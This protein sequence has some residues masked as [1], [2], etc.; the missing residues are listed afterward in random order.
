MNNSLNNNPFDFRKNFLLNFSRESN[1]YP[2][3]P[4]LFR[5]GKRPF[6]NGLSVSYSQKSEHRTTSPGSILNFR[7]QNQLK[8]FS[9][10]PSQENCLGKREVSQFI[11]NAL[12]N[13]KVPPELEM[14]SFGYGGS[15]AERV[16]PQFPVFKRAA[17]LRQ[18]LAKLEPIKKFS[19]KDRL[20]KNFFLPPSSQKMQMKR[21]SFLNQSVP[22]D[23][24]FYATSR[25]NSVGYPERPV[26]VVSNV[27]YNINNF[28]NNITVINNS[29]SFNTYKSG[30][31]KLND[32]LLS[33]MRPVGRRPPMGFVPRVSNLNFSNPNSR[34]YDT[35]K[36]I[37]KLNLSF[38]EK[39]GTQLQVIES[40]ELASKASHISFNSK[41]VMN[42]VVSNPKVPK[43]GV[44]KT[45]TCEK[46]IED[47][48]E[49][50][51][52]KIRRLVVQF[53]KDLEEDMDVSEEDAK[54]L[55]L[56][57]K[58][59]YDFDISEREVGEL[60]PEN[61]T[62]FR[63]FIID[64]YF[65]DEMERD[66]KIKHLYHG[67]EVALDEERNRSVRA[68][69]LVQVDAEEGLSRS[70]EIKGQVTFIKIKVKTFRKGI[71]E[72][73]HPSY[74]EDFSTSP[75]TDHLNCSSIQ[76]TKDFL[77]LESPKVRLL[78]DY[79]RKRERL[80]LLCRR[81]KKLHKKSK[82]NDEKIKKIFKRIMKSLLR[83]YRT[84]FLNSS[85]PDLNSTER[86]K[87]FYTYYFGDSEGQIAEFYDPLKRKLENPRFKSISTKYLTFLAQSQLF[88]RDLKEYCTSEM[89]FEVLE[90]YPEQLLKRFK[91]N[92][93][94]L[95][96]MD[97][98]KTKFEWIKH[99]LQAAI[100]H[101]MSIFKI[102]LKAANK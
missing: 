81:R 84:N 76:M 87:A 100:F 11:S 61:Q 18:N 13:Y 16:E 31:S 95:I 43:T 82:R 54:L 70:S 74:L 93:N 29:N 86:E 20:Q 78:Q 62:M 92:P 40:S 23:G 41:R 27:N 73:I 55:L 38:N 21:S 58:F 88:V 71:V 30:N 15:I 28:N 59:L 48:K 19:F 69:D 10:V 72:S 4:D 3:K 42:S 12:P 33:S 39:P 94:F 63:K 34:R 44:K 64:R 1:S 6:H 22:K 5:G 80:N 98:F 75:T 53:E 65:K 77:L 36:P 90:K 101:F 46:V 60:S 17:P 47:I 79:L 2:K 49:V 24:G 68:A 45:Q 91:E 32:N 67:I 26:H 9:V 89:V 99:E 96:E 50:K 35:F 37:S 7:Y 51:T 57:L 8:D 97:K 25:E 66:R 85:Q 14:P 102:C 83:K 56:M 52:E